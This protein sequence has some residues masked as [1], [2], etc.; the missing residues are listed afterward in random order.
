[1]PITDYLELNIAGECFSV[2]PRHVRLS[3]KLFHIYP[4]RGGKGLRSGLKWLHFSR[5]DGLFLRKRNKDVLLEYGTTDDA[6]AGFLER[7]SVKSYAVCFFYPSKKRSSDRIYGYALN[8]S[9]EPVAYIKIARNLDWGSLQR[10]CGAIGKLDSLGTLPFRY[11]RCLGC[12]P[13]SENSGV[14]VFSM[15]PETAKPL[16]FYEG[17]WEREIRQI[18]DSFAMSCRVVPYKDLANELW[19]REFN[20]KISSASAFY[21]A[22]MET[23]NEGVEV[24]WIHGDFVGHNFRKSDGSIWLF[25]WEEMTESG[26]VLADEIGFFLCVRRY[27]LGWSLKHVVS[28]FKR[29]YLDTPSRV[30]AIQAIAFLY[31]R[32]TCDISMEHAMVEQWGGRQVG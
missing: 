3:E 27:E 19:V 28:E 22:F 31:G 29:K 14:A 25:D 13:F 10:E 9:G 26:P 18:R 11:P 32:N 2:Y 16:A 6:L 4:L 24:S 12:E 15:L 21:K 7:C 30:A 17:I 1:M 20:K 23:L 8:T 5:M